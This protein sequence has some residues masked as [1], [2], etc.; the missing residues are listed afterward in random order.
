M[1]RAIGYAYKCGVSGGNKR[2]SDE[3]AGAPKGR[4]IGRQKPARIACAVTLSKHEKSGLGRI[5]VFCGLQKV[6]IW[7]V[8][9]RK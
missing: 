3:T 6:G 2:G 9:K 4:S 1:V 5:E 7:Y 8:V